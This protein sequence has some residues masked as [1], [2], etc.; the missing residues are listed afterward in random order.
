MTTRANARY[1]YVGE[2]FE[3]LTVTVTRK[4]GEKRVQ[5]ACSC[6]TAEHTVV[7]SEWG[8]TRSCGCLRR[9]VSSQVNATHRLTKSPE[10]RVWSHMIGRCTNPTDKN[11]PD[12]GGRGIGVCDRWRAF[13]NFLADMGSRPAG[14]SIDRIDN[15]G[16][17]EPGNCRWATATEQANNRRA[18]R[19]GTH[20]SK[21][22]EY[23]PEN[24]RLYRGG[25]VCRT[26]H[27]DN[28]RQRQAELRSA[29]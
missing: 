26:C 20:C 13:E 7:L 15:N 9:E 17:Y 27:R 11:Y 16:N 10:Y 29:S 24:T 28:E 21:G 14:T 25:R 4:P 22:H 23:T 1:I 19:R 6:G 2:V 5:C 8:K 12:Y 3:R 18:R